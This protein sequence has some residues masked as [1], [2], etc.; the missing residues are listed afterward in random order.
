MKPSGEVSI[1]FNPEI[2]SLFEYDQ[3]RAEPNIWA[4]V[5]AYGKSFYCTVLADLGQPL[6]TNILSHET[7]LQEY[8]QDF[9]DNGTEANAIPGPATS[10]YNKLRAQTGPLSITKSTIYQQYTCEV[11]IRK[12]TGSLII[13]ILVADL[14]FLQSLWKLFTLIT[15]WYV[16]RNDSTALYCEGCVRAKEADALAETT[17]LQE[18]TRRRMTA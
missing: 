9:T 4:Q 3:Q 10:S 2:K 5:D 13:A 8:T 11:P 15:T 12:S 6:I 18:G 7:L 1:L 17:K 16:C 14:V